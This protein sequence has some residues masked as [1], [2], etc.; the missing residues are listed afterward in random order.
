LKPI[1]ILGGSFDPVHNGHLRLAVEV[2]EALDFDS[3]RLVPLS[4]PNAEKSPVASGAQRLAMLK[5]AVADE[6]RLIPDDRELRRG[7]IS[8][9]VE[10]LQSLREE[11]PNQPLCLILGMDA[12]RRI[13]TWHQWQRLRTL[14]HIVIAARPGAVPG[15]VPGDDEVLPAEFISARTQNPDILRQHPAGSVLEQT[16]QQL[17]IS[18]TEIRARVRASRSIRYLLPDAVMAIIKEQKLYQEPA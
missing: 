1:G 18:S 4:L 10:T 11:Q 9:T 3:V 13:G 15:A 14:A 5:A 16:I 7:G 6:P 17:E 2:M 12:F 8:Y